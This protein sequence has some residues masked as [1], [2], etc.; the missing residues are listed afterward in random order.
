MGDELFTFLA[1]SSLDL[2]FF[3]FACECVAS[4]TK[5]VGGI[6]LTPTGFIQCGLDQYFFNFRDYLL[7]NSRVTR[8]ELL[9]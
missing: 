6:I 9:L 2:M 4:P 7:G 5:Q 8:S 3:Y 1:F